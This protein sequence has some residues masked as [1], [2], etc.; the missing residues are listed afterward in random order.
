MLDAVPYT[1]MK[2]VSHSIDLVCNI[3]QLLHEGPGTC[4]H[5]AGALL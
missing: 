4:S 1:E 5:S 3:V 2:P